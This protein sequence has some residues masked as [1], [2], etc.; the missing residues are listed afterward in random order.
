MRE[1]WGVPAYEDYPHR[2]PAQV[3][4]VWRRF[5]RKHHKNMEFHLESVPPMAMQ[6]SEHLWVCVDVSL[7][8]APVVAWSDFVD[9]ERAIH[10]PVPCT[11]TH[12]HFGA[13]QIREKALLEM[14]EVLEKKLAGV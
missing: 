1:I 5:W 6:L 7:N 14:A 13:S 8:H 3:Y 4:N 10:D 2:V 11:V 12:F 9:E